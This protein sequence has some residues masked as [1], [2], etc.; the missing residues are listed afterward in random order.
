M[1]KQ[2]VLRLE[3]Q[4][5]R[6][7][8]RAMKVACGIAG[9]ESLSFDP[10][11]KKLTVIGDF[12]MVKMV[13]KLRRLF[14]TEI[15][16]IGPAKKQ[17][18]K[19]EEDRKDK[20]VTYSLAGSGSFTYHCNNIYHYF[21]FLFQ[22][23]TLPT[24]T[25]IRKTL[26]ILSLV[27]LPCVSL[28]SFL[29][30]LEFSQ[31][32]LVDPTMK[33]DANQEEERKLEIHEH[34][35]V[36]LRRI[37]NNT[38]SLKSLTWSLKSLISQ[39]FRSVFRSSKPQSKNAEAQV[40][41]MPSSP[42]GLKEELVAS[43]PFPLTITERTHRA[44]AAWCKIRV[45]FHLRSMLLNKRKHLVDDVGKPQ[46]DAPELYEAEISSA[47]GKKADRR[48]TYVTE[49]T[50]MLVSY[51]VVLSEIKPYRFNSLDKKRLHIAKSPSFYACAHN[52]VALFFP[53]CNLN[54]LWKGGKQL[55]VN[56]KSIDLQHSN[57]LLIPD[58]SK[59]QKLTSLNLE[60]C[61]NLVGISSIQ[62]L[63]KLQYLNLKG[64]QSLKGLPSLIRLKFLKTLDLS[65][66]SNLTSLPPS[67]GSLSNLCEL[68]LR[69]CV[70]LDNLP[71]SVIHLMRSL[72][73]LNISGCSSLWKSICSDEDTAVPIST[74]QDSLPSA[75][76][77]I[78]ISKSTEEI[79]LESQ[80]MIKPVESEAAGDSRTQEISSNLK[81]IQGKEA[82]EWE[83]D[84][85]SFMATPLI[86]LL[87]SKL[88]SKLF[89]PP[90][91]GFSSSASSSSTSPEN[92][93]LELE[94]SKSTT[95]VQK[96]EEHQQPFKDDAH[97]DA[98][99]SSLDDWNE[100]GNAFGSIENDVVEMV[101][102][103]SSWNHD[104]EEVPES[105]LAW[106]AE[107]EQRVPG[108]VMSMKSAKAEAGVAGEKLKEVDARLI[109]G[110][111]ELSLLDKDLSR[112]LEEEE[113]IDGQLQ[114]LMDMKSGMVQQA[115]IME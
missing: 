78:L 34:D 90:A 11:G 17:D 16:S 2:L 112:I 50:Q 104:G 44:K 101:E 106:L 61:A 45:A 107:L 27:G 109:V 43:S 20:K 64:C 53:Y 84:E 8:I 115:L 58:L 23:T 18:E 108:T 74:H 102:R 40:V 70:K 30:S 87:P 21:F 1:V 72:E 96:E 7:K 76:C 35:V 56:L 28:E 75:T 82:I 88:R 54:Q 31:L 52:F 14:H 77:S 57:L 113:E 67:L 105:V 81:D 37:S 93:R 98:T 55:L 33:Q 73:T 42:Y 86:D 65:Y 62:Y 22:R 92:N 15:I 36:T 91:V 6:D 69:N 51:G 13:R 63:T 5:E 12:D 85:D 39:S 29:Q 3:L 26:Q 100:E 111:V 80:L 71:H 110:R 19:K 94:E 89:L 48:M 79:C 41:I 9:V 97:E 32:D 114:R 10:K 99:G 46:L 95:V 49:P 66:C 24:A 25:L 60:C 103:L 4:K 38:W 59:A 68:N 47:S 83:Q